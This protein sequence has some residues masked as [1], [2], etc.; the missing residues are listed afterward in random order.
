MK[1]LGETLLIA[2][3]NAGKL[4]EFAALFAPLGITVKGAAELGLAEPEETETSF[5]GN[6]RIKARAAMEASGLPVLADDSGI[7]VDAL[8]G[9]PGVYTADWAETPSGR[10]FMLAMTRT[11]NELEAI[12]APHPRVARFRCTLVL[13][14]PDGDEAI[15][16]GALEGAVTWP[17]RG[18]SG[19]GYD[20]I[21]VPDTY[22]KTLGELSFE[23]KN[24]LSHRA[25]AMAKLMEALSD[26]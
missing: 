24:A 21:F 16:D 5:V 26:A 18:L 12:H 7:E 2:T 8:G 3:H 4:E 1:P 6:A 13:M 17:P 23:E 19:H 11:N 9:A 14:W 20:P 15:F 25:R 10:D 22:E